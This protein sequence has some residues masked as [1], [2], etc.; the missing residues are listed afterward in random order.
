[1]DKL[2]SYGAAKRELGLSAHREQGRRKN[3]R[4]ENSHQVVRRRERKMQG[5]TSAGSAQRFLSTY[6]AVYNTF[7]LQRHLISRRTLRRFRTAAE[8]QWHQATVAA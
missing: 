4:A 5:F 8:A 3:N 1:S 7:N 6:A 2:P